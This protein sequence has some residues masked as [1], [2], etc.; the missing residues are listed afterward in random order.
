MSGVRDMLKAL[1]KGLPQLLPPPSGRPAAA[2]VTRELS[3][4]AVPQ[5]GAGITAL[6]IAIYWLESRYRTGIQTEY[7]Y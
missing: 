6:K 2:S 5:L 1:K 7:D 3:F 4:R